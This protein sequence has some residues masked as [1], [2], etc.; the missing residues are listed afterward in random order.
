MQI[1]IPTEI[2]E[3]SIPL[4]LSGKS[5]LGIAKTGTGK[6]LAYVLP[7]LNDLLDKN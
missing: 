7:I 5:I 2:Q 3:K 6:T 4:V 1:T